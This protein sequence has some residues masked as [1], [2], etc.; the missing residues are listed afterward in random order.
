MEDVAF[1]VIAANQKPD[2]ATIARFRRRHETALA[3]LFTDVLEL[4]AE[5]GLVKVGMIAIDGSKLSANASQES[6]RAMSRSFASCLSGPSGSISE[7]DELYGDRRGDELPE[8]LITRE[9]RQK[10]LADAKRRLIERRAKEQRPIPKSRTERLKEAKRRLEEEHDV[11]CQANAAYEQW[12]ETGRMKNGRRFG[13]PPKPYVPPELPDGRIN[14][15]D[16]DSGSMKTLRGHMQGYNVQAACNEQQI[17]IAAEVTVSP[18]TSGVSSRWS[19]RPCAS[20]RLPVSASARGGARRRRLLAPGADGE[21]HQPRD[22][23][24]DPAGR[25]QPPGRTPR[26]G[27]RLLR[28]HAPSA[29]ERLWPRS[30]QTTPV[31]DRTGLRSHQVQPQTHQ[32]HA[33]RQIRS[34]VRVAINGSDTQPVE[35]LQPPDSHHR[36]LGRP[37]AAVSD[38]AAATATPRRTPELLNHG[39]NGFMRQ[40]RLFATASEFSIS[41]EAAATPADVDARTSGQVGTGRTILRVAKQPGAPPS[42]V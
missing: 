23:G 16:L 41:R 30:L 1:R 19:P 5:A 38:P 27:G 13:S 3:E 22:A 32:V 8:E 14:V 4:C 33:K 11:H 31:D 39:K 7:E 18:R 26:M 2:H 24:P 25:R 17:V 37:P 40:P 9:G 35:A 34:Q 15:T 6:T 10:V 28:P 42:D 36:G 12:R 29:R 20:S 21:R